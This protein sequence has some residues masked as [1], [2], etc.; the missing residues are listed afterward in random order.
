MPNFYNQIGK[1]GGAWKGLYGRFCPE[2]VGFC[3]VLFQKW[4]AGNHWG[5]RLCGFSAHFPTFFSYLMR[6]KNI[7]IIYNWQKK[8]VF[9][10]RVKKTAL[11]NSHFPF[12]TGCDIL[13]MLHKQIFD[14]P[15]GEHWQIVFLSLLARPIGWSMSLCSNNEGYTFARVRL[16]IGAHSFYIFRMI[17][18]KHSG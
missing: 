1:T 7:K 3:P 4:A 14:H 9:G 10:Q 12:K 5:A 8:W 2:K 16:F 11:V 15:L 17:G 13:T 18:G 6:R